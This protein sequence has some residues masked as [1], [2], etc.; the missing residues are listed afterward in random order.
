[1]ASGGYVIFDISK[2]KNWTV[3]D[4]WATGK[5]DGI[6]K[7][8]TYTG[9]PILIHA[10]N[11]VVI[12]GT[13][14]NHSTSNVNDFFNPPLVNKVTSEAHGTGIHIDFG[15]DIYVYEDDTIEIG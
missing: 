9:K 5:L 10:I 14:I 6:Y 13:S 12:P 4:N 2:V 1:M 11:T 3:V 7:R 15:Q 8:L